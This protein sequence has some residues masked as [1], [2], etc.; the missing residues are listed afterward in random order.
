MAKRQQKSSDKCRA[1]GCRKPR[2]PGL[3]FCEKCLAKNDAPE[4]VVRLTEVEAL[5][6]GKADAEL[7]N[8]QQGIQI[9]KFEIERV[10]R[11]ANQ[12]IAELNQ[13]IAVAEAEILAKKPA[14]LALVN[15]F[16]AK[17][18]IPAD[19][20]TIDPDTRRIRDLSKT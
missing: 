8:M 7:R 11:E 12:R 13:L 20:M 16:A 9:N 14:Y 4:S 18:G 2:V 3:A 10:T 19:K 1:K 5:R 6:W 17:Y 15:E